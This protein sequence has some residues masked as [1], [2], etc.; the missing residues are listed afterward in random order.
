MVHPKILEN[1]SIDSNIYQGFALGLGI[2]RLAMLKYNICDMRQLYEND[3]D[4][5]DSQPG[6]SKSL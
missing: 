6:S 4:F 5:L 3:I 1:F 2:E